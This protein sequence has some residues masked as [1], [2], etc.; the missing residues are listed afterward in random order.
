MRL[1][2]VLAAAGVLVTAFAVTPAASA[3][4]DTAAVTWTVTITNLTPPGPGAP[5]SQPLSPPVFAVHRSGVHVWQ[6]GQIASHAVAAVAEDAN[7]PVLVSALSKQRG[8]VDAFAGPGGPIPSGQSA[9]YTLRARPGQ[10]VSIVTMLV[11]TNDGFTGV[12]AI[13][14]RGPQV[15]VR[16]IAYDAGSEV[17]NELT[18]HIP[19]PCCNNPFVRA[20]EGDLI[21]PHE[22]I[23]GRGDLNPAVYGWPEPVA[24]I[25][26]T[27]AS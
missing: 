21:R 7:N 9:T 6:V 3:A 22:G 11:N 17:N 12:D 24:A 1:V 16:T 25:T 15:A 8:V 27:R 14:L 10:R 23:T 2:R 5:G 19:G 4:A 20:P 13:E 18:T 26:F